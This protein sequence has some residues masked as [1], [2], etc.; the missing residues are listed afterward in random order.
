M[1]PNLIAVAAKSFPVLYRGAPYNACVKAGGPIERKMV[2]PALWALDMDTLGF[3]VEYVAGNSITGKLCITLPPDL[4]TSYRALFLLDGVVNLSVEVLSAA[5]TAVKDEVSDSGYWEKG[6]M[7]QMLT[8]IPQR[9]N[10]VLLPLNDVRFRFE[11]APIQKLI[12]DGSLPFTKEMKWM[13]LAD[14]AEIRSRKTQEEE[15]LRPY[16]HVMDAFRTRTSI[17]LVKHEV[18]ET[19]F[20]RVLLDGLKLGITDP[21]LLAA[22]AHFH[23]HILD[24]QVEMTAAAMSRI[25]DI[26]REGG[27]AYLVMGTMEDRHR[28]FHSSLDASTSFALEVA[29]RKPDGPLPNSDELRSKLHNL[30]RQWRTLK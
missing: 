28:W 10:D 3:G 1:L 29:K 13:G 17:R 11:T 20:R 27:G 14:P 4:V 24:A 26:A 6:R 12:D 23:Y 5:I 15:A 19:I 18:W 9:L 22:I 16:R 21:L 7:K 25:T 2:Q 30:L 8:V